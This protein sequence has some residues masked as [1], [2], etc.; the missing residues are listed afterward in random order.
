MCMSSGRG[1]PEQE[2]LQLG[3][4]PLNLALVSNHTFEL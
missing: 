1:L 2:A 3:G 4:D